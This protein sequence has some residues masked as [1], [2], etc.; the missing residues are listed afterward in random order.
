MDRRSFLSRTLSSSRAIEGGSR[1]STLI[2]IPITKHQ[3]KALSPH[4]SSYHTSLSHPH[5]LLEFSPS[6]LQGLRTSPKLQPSSTAQDQVKGTQGVQALRE[7]RAQEE[8]PR[9]RGPI[10][11]ASLRKGGGITGP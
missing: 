4:H 10:S 3:C 11:L 8:K 1:A 5:T 7:S 6:K 9:L 2:I